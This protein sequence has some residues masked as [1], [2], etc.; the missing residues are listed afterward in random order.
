M[1]KN[2]MHDN[3]ETEL[4]AKESSTN[5][6]TPVLS[7]PIKFAVHPTVSVVTTRVEA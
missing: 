2:F 5:V 7:S 4:F 6:A 3:V 1:Q